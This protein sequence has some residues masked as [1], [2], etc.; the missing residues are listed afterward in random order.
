VYLDAGDHRV[1]RHFIVVLDK[2]LR[3]ACCVDL[4]QLDR[5]RAGCLQK[6]RSSNGLY[7]TPKLPDASPHQISWL[8]LLEG[9]APFHPANVAIIYRAHLEEPVL[10]NKGQDVGAPQPQQ[11]RHRQISAALHMC[12]QA[13]VEQ[14]RTTAGTIQWH[15]AVS[16]EMA[17]LP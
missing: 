3:R 2:Q 7:M 15:I 17:L 11:D 1:G 14:H 4:Q 6:R 8:Y 5:V 10:H 9:S 12:Q 16:F 13:G